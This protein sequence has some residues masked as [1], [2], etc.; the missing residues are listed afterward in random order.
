MHSES[1]HY[2]E[3]AGFHYKPCESPEIWT[4]LESHFI[5]PAPIGSRFVHFSASRME[6][7]IARGEDVLLDALM[8]GLRRTGKPGPVAETIE[9]PYIVGTSSTVSPAVADPAR[10][11]WLVDQAGTSRE[12]I[13]Q[14]MPAE[15]DAIPGTRHMT[16]TGGLYADG[17]TAGYYDLCPGM[18]VKADACVYLA[19]AEDIRALAEDMRVKAEDIVLITRRECEVLLAQVEKLLD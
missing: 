8:S 17:H 16:V 12:H 18:P 10:I 3:A 5:R 1:I 14:V 2:L 13:V 7:M 15:A 9:M 4:H 6:E 19:T 11:L